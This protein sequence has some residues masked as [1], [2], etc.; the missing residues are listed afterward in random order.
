MNIKTDNT[1]KTCDNAIFAIETYRGLKEYRTVSPDITVNPDNMYNL[2][3][4]YLRL[5]KQAEMCGCD[6]AMFH[7]SLGG[8][9]TFCICCNDVFS[10]AADAEDISDE[11]FD[12][13]YELWKSGGTDKVLEWIGFKRGIAPRAWRKKNQI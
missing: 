12:T 1:I 6:D 4:S 5:I 11:D 3:K 2:A 7:L 8:N 9:L 13:V 10:P